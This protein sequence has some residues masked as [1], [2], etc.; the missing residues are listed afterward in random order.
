MDVVTAF[1]LCT[2]CHCSFFQNTFPY[3][4][5]TV[6]QP[7]DCALASGIRY[8]SALVLFPFSILERMAGPSSSDGKHILGE[9]PGLLKTF[10]EQTHHLLD[11]M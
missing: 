10:V 11:H 9:E 6:M 7:C 2:K 3:V 4:P 8:L 5:C 1:Q